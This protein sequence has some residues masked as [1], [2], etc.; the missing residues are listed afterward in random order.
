MHPDQ[1]LRFQYAIHISYH[2]VGLRIV[3]CL[4]IQKNFIGSN[5]DDSF[6]TDVSNSFLSP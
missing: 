1:F 6:T 5:T 3:I 4:C 2:S